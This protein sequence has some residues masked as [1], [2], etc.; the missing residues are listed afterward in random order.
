MEQHSWFRSFSEIAE[1]V[2]L[3]S[4]VFLLYELMALELKFASFQLGLRG[5]SLTK[6]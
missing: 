4:P 6:L 3:S 2:S 5:G 1:V